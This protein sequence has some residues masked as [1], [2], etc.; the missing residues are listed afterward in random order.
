MVIRW[1]PP[2]E[3]QHKHSLY[4]YEFY[5]NND[6]CHSPVYGNASNNIRGFYARSI[7]NWNKRDEKEKKHHESK[8]QE[9]KETKMR[10]GLLGLEL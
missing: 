7:L 10:D 3:K 4:E 8:L 2:Q 5:Y 1:H 6:K 9:A